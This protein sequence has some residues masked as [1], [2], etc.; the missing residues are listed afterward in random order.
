MERSNARTIAA[1]AAVQKAM[2]AIRKISRDRGELTSAENIARKPLP[3]E[4]DVCEVAWVEAFAL[5]RERLDEDLLDLSGRSWP[6][7]SPSRLMYLSSTHLTG[8]PV[9][10]ASHCRATGKPQ[11]RE[12]RERPIPAAAVPTPLRAA[13]PPGEPVCRSRFQTGGRLAGQTSPGPS[14]P[15]CRALWPA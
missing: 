12:P 13:S 3:G 7:I 9:R 15:G 2:A 5:L 14:P 11:N 6:N 1:P 4:G 8:R 10:A